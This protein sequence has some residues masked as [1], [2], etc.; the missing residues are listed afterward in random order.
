MIFGEL[1]T[2]SNYNDDEKRTTGG[3]NG[4]G[5]KLANIF[6]TEFIVEIGDAKRGIHYTQTWRDNMHIVEPA[7]ITKLPAKTRSFV[8][9]TYYPDFKRFNIDCIDDDHFRLFHRRTIDIAGTANNK[10]SVFFNDEKINVAN[11]KQYIEMY[12]PDK[13][14]YYDDNTDRWSVGCIYK[15]DSNSETVSFVNS[16]STYHGGTHCNHVIDNIIKTLI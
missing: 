5:A 14:I 12:Y 1:L 3:R 2:S 13:E 10:L 4:Y 9:V 15:P 11:F 16:I 6:S 8:K 7:K